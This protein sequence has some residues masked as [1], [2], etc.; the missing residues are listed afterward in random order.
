MSSAVS[1][2][3]DVFSD[4]VKGAADIL[5]STAEAVSDVIDDIDVEDA[6][7]TYLQTGNPYLAA[8]AATD[9]DEDLSLIDGQSLGTTPDEEGSRAKPSYEFDETGEEDTF[10]VSFAPGEQGGVPDDIQVGGIPQ[11]VYDA[12]GNIAT[13]IIQNMKERSEQDNA[14][15]QIYGDESRK[16]INSFSGILSDVSNGKYSKSPAAEYNTRS[17]LDAY[18]NQDMDSS[19]SA[20]LLNDYNNAKQ[21]V[22][23]IVENPSSSFGELAMQ[24][25]P[26][27]NFMKQRNI[28]QA[29]EAVS[30]VFQ[31]YVEN[32]PQSEQAPGDIFQP[33]LQE[34]GIL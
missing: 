18:Y 15:A 30:N 7:A 34:K 29:Q 33:Y 13:G 22:A 31:N 23:N 6:A 1:S 8:F 17:V 21:K 3:T 27:Y 14:T 28:G 9:L 5:G 4:A 11:G 2:I 26:F 10:S 32:M 12:F 16:L 19:L 24:G 25:N 20:G